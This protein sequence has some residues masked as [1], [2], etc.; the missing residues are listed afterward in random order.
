VDRPLSARHVILLLALLVL[1]IVGLAPIIVMFARS[2]IVDGA[3][4]L[5]NYRHLLA[6]GRSWRLLG[7]SV[8]LALITAFICTLVGLPLGLLFAK[9]DLPL[10]RA[11]V[12]LFT[13]PL[14]I[15]PYI[16]A[17]SWAD[18]L[19]PHGLA[20]RFFGEAMAQVATRFLFGL[21][22]CVLVLASTFMPA[23]MLAT[24]TFTRAIDPGMEDAARLSGRPLSVLREIIIPLIRPGVMLA[25]TLVFLLMLGE[26]GVP[27]FL[28]YSVFAVESFAQFTVSYNFGAAAALAVPLALL[29]FAILGIEWL[30]LREKI[31]PLRPASDGDHIYLVPLRSHG[32]WLFVLVSVLCAIV[33]IAPLLSLVLQAGSW[34]SYAR[35]LQVVSGS[36]LRSIFLATAGAT[37]LTALG[38][39]VG[40]VIRTRAMSIWRAVDA[41]TVLLFALPGT[42]IGMGLIALW[43]RPA[44]NFIYATPLIIVFGYLAQYTALT[45]RVT[46]AGLSL[47]PASM[48]EAAASAGASW[49]RRLGLIVL[50]LIKNALVTGWLIAYI[51]CLRDTGITMLVYPPG[52]DTLPVRI[53]TLMANGAPPLVAAACLLMIV[54]TA[55]PLIG[56]ASLLRMQRRH[57]WR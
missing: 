7:N 28:R 35:A 48:E 52:Y 1:A 33:V 38:F 3:F 18:T 2:L 29:T 55:L 51:F 53:F 56:V 15:P 13:L 21:P 27:T 57:V 22:G 37:A 42:V 49:M 10:R 12:L 9:T 39:F 46:V 23:V 26:F 50:P 16:T 45:G 30:A 47:V 24:M 19:A 6:T 44:T 36:L 8:G 4:S 32:I 5:E 14:V 43:N 41:G 20:S 34:Q 25:A 11:F 31:Q 17:V 54:A 40:Y